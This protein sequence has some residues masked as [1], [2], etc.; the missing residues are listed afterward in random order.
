MKPATLPY[1]LIWFRG[2]AGLVI[3]FLCLL[4][5][6]LAGIFCTALLA[7]G[8]M[9]DIF[10]GVLARKFNVVTPDLRI[11]DSRCDLLFWIC[12][13]VGVH[14][15]WPKL[16]ATTW[17][18]VAV[19]GSLEVTAR[20]ISHVRFG[21][22]ASTHHVLSKIFTLFLWALV[23][24][25]FLIGGTG[26]LFWATFALGVISQLEAIAIMMVV[27]HWVFDVK[28]IGS[29]LKMRSQYKSLKISQSGQTPRF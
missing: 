3:L 18:M 27:P 11:W 6:P 20:L 13:I 15:L 14:I 17:L 7:L 23:S 22:E 8:V 25:A 16:W 4:Q 12:T 19:I 2:M 28:G 9:S 29:A 5:L 1:L 24:Q 10:D 26:I 21:R